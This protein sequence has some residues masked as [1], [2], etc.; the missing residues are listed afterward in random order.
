MVDEV[1]VMEVLPGQELVHLNHV[2]VVII[3]NIA[4]EGAEGVK[5]WG[6]AELLG[7]EPYDELVSVEVTSL[8]T[9]PR[10]VGDPDE[11]DDDD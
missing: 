1:E 11:E 8:G 10:I 6:F 3:M 5:S 2:K 9:V 7:L 4:D